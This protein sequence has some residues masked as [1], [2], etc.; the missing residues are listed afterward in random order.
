MI[1][2]RF[3]RNKLA[4]VGLALVGLVI[5]VAVTAPLIAPADPLKISISNRTKPPSSEYRFGTDQFGR[6]ILSRIIHGAKIS[7]QVGVFSVLFGALVGIV[8][9]SVG[10][11]F[12]GWLDSVI[13]LIMDT[14]R[15]SLSYIK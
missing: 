9:G 4:L 15:K 3:L 11:Y 12:G 10:G 7:L 6:D 13:V 2:K 5:A 14:I 8:L 1:V